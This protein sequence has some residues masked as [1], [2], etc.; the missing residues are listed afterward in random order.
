ML[1]TLQ[2]ARRWL[3]WQRWLAAGHVGDGL[4]SMLQMHMPLHIMLGRHGQ[5]YSNLVHDLAR[6]GDESVWETPGFRELP[7]ADVRLTEDGRWHATAMGQ[8]KAENVPFSV[9]Q[10]TD[11]RQIGRLVRVR[12]PYTDTEIWHPVPRLG[13]YAATH[14]RATETAGLD[15]QAWGV[16][17]ELWKLRYYLRERSWGD[18]DG[19]SYEEMERRSDFLA[20]R[21]VDPF[22]AS[23][24]GGESIDRRTASAT[25]KWFPALRL[26]YSRGL[27]FAAMH[28][29]LMNGL[30]VDIE[31]M[32]LAEF[33]RRHLSKDPH[34]KIN[35]GQLVWYSRV[36]PFT[37]EVY[38]D[39]RWKLSVCPNDMARSRNEW[40]QIVRPRYS[41]QELLDLVDR[42]SPQ[43]LEIEG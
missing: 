26:Y 6:A 25:S 2:Q 32:P 9:D 17:G 1:Q 43:T 39:Y 24:P 20:R 13:L 15:G 22:H 37:G 7:N 27:V 40:E 34:D 35:N 18:L 28:G 16:D 30:A 21:K 36:N 5:A 33:K 38:P 12:F 8:W 42:H 41:S 23:P 31:R 29:E 10:M 19:I 11:P 14:A 3:R 4:T